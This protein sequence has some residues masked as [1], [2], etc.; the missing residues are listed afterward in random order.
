[1][2]R[3][4]GSVPGGPS[5]VSFTVVGNDADFVTPEDMLSALHEDEK[6]L[7]QIMPALYTLCADAEDV[8]T[9]SLLENWIDQSQRHGWFLFEST[10]R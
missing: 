6:R 4:W 8:A 1:M 9:A 2:L 3:Y 10:Q 7:V 5:S